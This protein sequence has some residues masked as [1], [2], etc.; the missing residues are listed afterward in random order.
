LAH[1]S[2]NVTVPLNT[3]APPEES[4]ESTQK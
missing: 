2:R 3:S 4:L 1:E